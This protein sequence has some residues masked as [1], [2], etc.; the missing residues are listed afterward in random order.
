M[1]NVI[2]QINETAINKSFDS[3]NNIF[4]EFRLFSS[5]IFFDVFDWITSISNDFLK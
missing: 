1:K 5:G 4:D 3:A 2:L